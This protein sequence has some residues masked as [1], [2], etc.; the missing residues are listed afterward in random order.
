MQNEDIKQATKLKKLRAIVHVMAKNWILFNCLIQPTHNLILIAFWCYK[1]HF[2][3]D[4]ITESSL[5]AKLNSLLY[6]YFF[7]TSNSCFFSQGNSN[8]FNTVQVS[9]GLV[10]INELNEVVVGILLLCATYSSTIFWFL[11]TVENLIML[12]IASFSEDSKKE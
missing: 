1:R 6:F 10:G 3:N 12:K 11:C 9:S 4:L 2:L 7:T 8:S 5:V